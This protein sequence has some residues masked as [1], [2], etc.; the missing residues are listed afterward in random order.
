M[1]DN[2]ENLTTEK[3]SL[4]K[5]RRPN[6]HRNQHQTAPETPPRDEGDQLPVENNVQILNKC[7]G[8]VEING[9][10]L[11]NVQYLNP[12]LKIS[13]PRIEDI[14]SFKAVTLNLNFKSEFVT[15]WQEVVKKL[16]NFG[17]VEHK[18]WAQKM[19]NYYEKR[20]KCI[21]EYFK[22]VTSNDNKVISNLRK[23]K[24]RAVLACREI[25]TKYSYRKLSMFVGRETTDLLSISYSEGLIK[26][27]GHETSEEFI[28]WSKTNGL[29]G[30]FDDD[31]PEHLQLAQ[32]FFSLKVFNASDS[33]S[34]K[35]E[36]I[37]FIH[38]KDGERKQ[39][40]AQYIYVMDPS[41]EGCF[42]SGYFI[43][44]NTTSKNLKTKSP[45]E[46]KSPLQ[47]IGFLRDYSEG[48]NHN[49]QSAELPV[50]LS[51]VSVSIEERIS[52]S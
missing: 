43:I 32:D 24:A 35:H 21:A 18:D 12:F 22:V 16:E 1:H 50:D 13:N 19:R 23:A 6:F 44:K 26:A 38:T 11:I 51:A 5:V 20:P 34:S 36:Y 45:I 3:R 31:C 7:M 41:S 9:K 42:V 14:F 17:D 30:M 4:K 25:E 52:M 39:I 29:P 27:L 8:L 40:T 2:N 37:T 15:P 46:I 47:E 49:R 48:I 33:I 10:I 28:N